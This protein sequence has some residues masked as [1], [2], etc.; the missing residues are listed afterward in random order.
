MFNCKTIVLNHTFKKELAVLTK[1]KETIFYYFHVPPFF[2]F[3]KKEYFLINVLI[4]ISSIPRFFGYK[5]IVYYRHNHRAQTYHGP[6]ANYIVTEAVELT[7]DKEEYA[8]DRLE[9][10]QRQRSFTRRWR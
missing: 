7:S 9:G 6:S 10:R 1:K 3:C 2:F 5:S 8:R 4:K